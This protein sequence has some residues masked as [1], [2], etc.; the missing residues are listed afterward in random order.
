MR[1]DN[2]PHP[3]SEPAAAGLPDYA[4]DD[5]TTCDDVRLGRETDGQGS[6]GPFRE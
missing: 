2:Y 4:A 3:V 6:A 1:Q 5:S